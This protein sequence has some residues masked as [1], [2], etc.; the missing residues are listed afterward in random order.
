VDPDQFP[1]YDLPNLSSDGEEDETAGEENEGDREKSKEGVGNELSLNLLNPENEVK[2]HAK[3]VLMGEESEE[4]GNQEGV[5][6]K[7][8]RMRKK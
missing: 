3:L 5:R 4:E 2:D 7:T 8:N 6:N 1:L